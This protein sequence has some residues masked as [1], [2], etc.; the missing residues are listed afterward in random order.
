MEAKRAAGAG[1][2]QAAGPPAGA[3]TSSAGPRE[4]AGAGQPVVI[5]SGS[6]KNDAGNQP[7]S[8][9]RLRLQGAIVPKPT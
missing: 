5:V 2:L 4:R 3:A 9:A 6:L 8:A 1:I 7:R